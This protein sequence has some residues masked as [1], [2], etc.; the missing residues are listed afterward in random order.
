MASPGKPLI[1]MYDPAEMRVSVNLPQTLVGVLRKET[2]KVEIP[3]APPALASIEL[4]E[5]IVLPTADP[6]SQMMQIRLP[7]PAKSAG[8]VPGMFARAYFPTNARGGV[9]RIKVPSQAVFRRS[10]LTAVYVVDKGGKPQLRLVRAGKID[11]GQTEI[12]AGLEAGEKV[13]LD[14]LAAIPQR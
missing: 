10:E 12:L 13:V 3:A 11:A 7:L 5:M 9:T 6:V 1:T 4:R 2:V 8:L 14:P